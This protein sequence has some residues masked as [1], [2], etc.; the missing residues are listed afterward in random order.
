LEHLPESCAP[1]PRAEYRD[2][3]GWHHRF[4]DIAPAIE[5]PVQ[6]AT[7]EFENTSQ[8]NPAVLAEVKAELSGAPLVEVHLQHAAGHNVSLH[9]VARSYHLR[10]IAFAEQFRAPAAE[11]PLRS[12]QLLD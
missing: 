2:T 10:V 8:M 1:V 11:A 6:F 5:V 7:V 12:G 4:W 3:V 9:H